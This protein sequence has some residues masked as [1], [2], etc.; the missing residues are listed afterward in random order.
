MLAPTFTYI[1]T[2]YECY[3]EK[4]LIRWNN[5]VNNTVKLSNWPSKYKDSIANM[6][7]VF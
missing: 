6:L 5:I 3:V 2:Y 4:M 1:Y 7:N